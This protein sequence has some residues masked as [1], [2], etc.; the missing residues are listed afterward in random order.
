MDTERTH[1]GNGMDTDLLIKSTYQIRMPRYAAYNGVSRKD[2]LI[3]FIKLIDIFNVL[4]IDRGL[5]YF[6][7]LS[8]VF[9][10]IWMLTK[11]IVDAQISTLIGTCFLALL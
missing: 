3:L 1:H 10:L 9:M 8:L 2:N 4:Y 6:S 5:L 7:L 11:P